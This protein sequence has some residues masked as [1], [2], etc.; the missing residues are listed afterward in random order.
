MEQH[1]HRDTE[2]PGGT[3][4]LRRKPSRLQGPGG[5][6]GG[7]GLDL[8]F[9]VLMMDRIWVVGMENRW[10]EYFQ[11]RKQLEQRHKNGERG[12]VSFDERKS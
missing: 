7:R 3:G 10:G 11:Q 4:D 6:L 2:L 8:S 12:M 1:R 9:E 5:G